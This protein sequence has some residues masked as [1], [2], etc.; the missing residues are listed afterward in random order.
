MEKISA[1]K[2][3]RVKI[4]G[5]NGS[6]QHGE[7]F[8]IGPNKWG[9]GSRLGVRGDD[10]ETYWVNEDDTAPSAAVAT[11]PDP[12]ETFD[13]GDRVAFT[14]R[15][16][17]GEGTVFWIGA[18]RS[19]GQR[20]GVRPD[21][22]EDAVWLDARFARRVE[23]RA[24]PARP[25]P[26]ADDGYVD[27]GFVDEDVIDYAPPLGPDDLPPVAPIDDDWADQMASLVDE[28]EDEAPFGS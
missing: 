15:G 8:W 7:V 16:Q 14:Q 2:G 20:L 12:G 11:A 1:K 26:L 27:D 6:G 17:Q 28:G 9:P 5:G 23:G 19:G 10:G 25:A 3:D 4:V 13:K 21:D 18:G 24:P 22:S